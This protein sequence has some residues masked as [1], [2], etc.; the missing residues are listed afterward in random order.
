MHSRAETNRPDRPRKRDAVP[1]GPRYRVAVGHAH[2]VRP[3]GIVGAI[4]AEGG[5]TGRDLGRIDIF[6]TYSLVEIG[7]HISPAAFGRISN[8]KVSGQSLKIQ[9][10]TSPAHS[11]GASSGPRRSGPGHER[12]ARSAYR[13]AR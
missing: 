1:A 2:G 6:D 7:G 8:A 11:G 13:A 12:P 4:T 5:L 3:A 10:D 9:L